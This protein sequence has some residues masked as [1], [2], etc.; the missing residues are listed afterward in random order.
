MKPIG[1]AGCF[2]SH[3]WRAIAAVAVIGGGAVRQAGAQVRPGETR[4]RDTGAQAQARRGTPAPPFVL[5]ADSVT[6]QQARFLEHIGRLTF[7][8][9]PAARDERTLMLKDMTA[10]PP[11]YVVGPRATL[12]PEAGAPWVAG[13]WAA[14]GRVMARL[15]LSGPYPPLHLAA[16]V[17]YVCVRDMVGDTTALAM[18][19]GVS[20]NVVASVD[21]LPLR[22]QHL[23]FPLF[24]ARFTFS[25]RDDGFCFPCNTSWCCAEM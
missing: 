23:T 18:L 9:S 5:H 1:L 17:T 22:V 25:P 2:S 14:W 13:D 4:G 8:H 3:W 12:E 15:T 16:G 21:S 24:V 6:H 7:V 11:R 20:H 10:Q 19:I